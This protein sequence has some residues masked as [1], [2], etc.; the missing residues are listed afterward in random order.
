MKNLIELEL[1]NKIQPLVVGPDVASLSLLYQNVSVDVVL[2][3]VSSVPKPKVFSISH[4]AR[5]LKCYH[6]NI[7]LSLT[8]GHSN[9]FF[10]HT[11]EL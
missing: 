3:L 2:R 9:S 4:K 10:V 5:Q 11:A 1:D 6:V 7:E 8:V